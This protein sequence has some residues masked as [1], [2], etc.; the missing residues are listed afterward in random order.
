[1]HMTVMHLNVTVPLKGLNP[2]G[3]HPIDWANVVAR[4]RSAAFM[5]SYIFLLGAALFHGLYGLRNILFELNPAS[6]LKRG[7]SIVLLLCGLA[8]FVYGTWAAIAGF[9]LAKAM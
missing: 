8:L 7:V 6:W 1:M 4:G 3:G 9:S 2:A 5:V